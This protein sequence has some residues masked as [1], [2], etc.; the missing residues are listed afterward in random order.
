M[1][2]AGMGQEHW[3]VVDGRLGLELPDG[4]DHEDF[5]VS[6]LRHIGLELELQ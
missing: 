6:R 1:E 4:E 2:H 3:R 5:D